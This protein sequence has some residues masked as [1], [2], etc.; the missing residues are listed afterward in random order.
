[1]LAY[2]NERHRLANIG[3]RNNG[4]D[5]RQGARCR[6]VDVL[7]APMRQR[8]AQDRGMQQIFGRDIRNKAAESTQEAFVLDSLDRTADPGIRTT[9]RTGS[10]LP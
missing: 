9:H 5:A 4:D 7:N 8:A 1:M 10:V 3:G 6:R 2:G